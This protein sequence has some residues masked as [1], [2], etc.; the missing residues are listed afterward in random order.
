MRR[1][2][3]FVLAASSVSRRSTPRI[4]LDASALRNQLAPLR[5]RLDMMLRRAQKESRSADVRSLMR[6]CSV[7][8]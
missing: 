8:M 1:V 2:G 5:Y 6:M 7:L 3:V 4:R